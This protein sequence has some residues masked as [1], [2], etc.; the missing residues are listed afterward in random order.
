MMQFRGS[1][2]SPHHPNMKG[3]R[4]RYWGQRRRVFHARMERGPASTAMYSGTQGGRGAALRGRAV[5]EQVANS[6]TTTW[7]A[8]TGNTSRRPTRQSS[9]SRQTWTSTRQNKFTKLDGGIQGETKR[10][11]QSSCSWGGGGPQQA[12]L[13]NGDQ[14]WCQDS[15]S[16]L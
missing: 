6:I 9:A 8:S 1:G 16:W 5:G 3:P 10:R 4:W 11:Y 7:G 15:Y 14:Q 2:F 12:P 13:H